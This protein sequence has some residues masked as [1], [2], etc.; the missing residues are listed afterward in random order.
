MV[1]DADANWLCLRILMSASE[2]PYNITITIMFC[3]RWMNNHRPIHCNCIILKKTTDKFAE[4]DRCDEKHYA[5]WIPQ[6]V[7]E[8]G[9]SLFLCAS[10]IWML[11][12]IRN[13]LVCHRYRAR[14]LGLHY[15]FLF[16]CLEQFVW[17]V[18]ALVGTRRWLTP[19][20]PWMRIN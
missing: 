15:W 5:E 18:W 12:P 16:P 6:R 17:P 1:L 8:P 13:M 19:F 4:K 9:I 3:I 7:V 14:D 20:Q 11:H 2:Q 10:L